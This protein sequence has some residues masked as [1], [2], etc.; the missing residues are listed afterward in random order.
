M[1]IF[2]V[3]LKFSARGWFQLQR[4]SKGHYSVTQKQILT[5]ITVRHGIRAESKLA[6]Y[7]C[8]QVIPT[9]WFVLLRPH[10]YYSVAPIDAIAI[11]TQNRALEDSELFPGAFSKCWM[12]RL[13]SHSILHRHINGRSYARRFVYG[14][15]Y[16]RAL[17]SPHH[18]IR[19]LSWLS[20]SPSRRH[21]VTVKLYF[22]HKIKRS[23]KALSPLVWN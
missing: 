8:S 6:F 22:R 4:A 16:K 23:S 11:T 15:M 13:A 14:A 21:L 19:L 17:I 1:D 2:C 7:S 12:F 20:L 5:Q 9:R 10:C 18:F 3:V